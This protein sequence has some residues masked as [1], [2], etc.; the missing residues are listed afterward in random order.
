M[1]PTTTTI[2]LKDSRSTNQVTRGGHEALK[3]REN[4]TALKK[5][6]EMT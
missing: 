2:I 6:R 4:D 3:I 5:K 1:M